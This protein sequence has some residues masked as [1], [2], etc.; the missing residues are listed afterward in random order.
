M[1]S[2]LGRINEAVRRRIAQAHGQDEPCRPTLHTW[3]GQSI[4]VM[5]IPRCEPKSWPTINLMYRNG[6]V[7]RVDPN[8]FPI[9]ADP[10]KVITAEYVLEW[11]NA[12]TQCVYLDPEMFTV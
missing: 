11:I 9:P 3:R 5:H 12:V 4:I 6:E 7:R 8:K 1:T 2:E 10:E